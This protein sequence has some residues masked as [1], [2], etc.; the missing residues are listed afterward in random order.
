MLLNPK[1]WL[2]VLSRSD[3]PKGWLCHCGRC[4]RDVVIKRKEHLAR[5]VSCGCYRKDGLNNPPKYESDAAVMT[6]LACGIE[7]PAT[8]AHFTVSRRRA[9]GL[10]GTCRDCRKAYLASFR[11]KHKQAIRAQAAQWKKRHPA[12]V[13]ADTMARQ[14]RQAMAMPRWVNARDIEAVYSES[15][16][17]SGETGVR[18]EVD[19]IVPLRGRGVSGLHVPWNLRVITREANGLKGNRFD[20]ALRH[21]GEGVTDGY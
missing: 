19:H 2:S 11:A 16:R 18:H 6:C 3:N 10:Q 8:K 4:G 7:K 5:I 13:C 14:A 17:I 12:K 20:A 1:S 21:E 15:A 9:V